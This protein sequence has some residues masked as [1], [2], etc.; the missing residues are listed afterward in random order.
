MLSDVS[1]Q[2]AQ[3]MCLCLYKTESMAEGGVVM[4]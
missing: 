3:N 4:A 2:G 1:S